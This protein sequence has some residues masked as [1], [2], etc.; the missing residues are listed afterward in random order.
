M[1]EKSMALTAFWVWAT[2][3]QIHFMFGSRLGFSGTV[4]QMALLWSIFMRLLSSF[5]VIWERIM[6]E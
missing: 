6:C 1:H 5:A 4:D 2:G 3:H